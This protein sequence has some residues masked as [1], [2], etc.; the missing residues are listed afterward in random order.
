MKHPNYRDH[1]DI[2]CNFKNLGIDHGLDVRFISD[3]CCFSC[4]RPGD[5]CESY[6]IG[7]KCQ[8]ANFIVQGVGRAIQEVSKKGDMFDKIFGCI[9]KISQR[10]FDY[11]SRVGGKD[12]EYWLGQKGRWEGINCSN[13]F[14]VF[15][16]MIGMGIII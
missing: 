10:E 14:S 8:M 3:S 9:E 5:L 2:S 16:E 1:T 15:Y 7:E 11:N 4:G 13:M 6:R 12:M